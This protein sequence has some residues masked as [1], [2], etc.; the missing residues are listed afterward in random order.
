MSSDTSDIGQLGSFL[1]LAFVIPGF[2]YLGF[3][4]LYFPEQYENLKELYPGE[5]LPIF[6]G[7][8]GGLLLTSICFG[9]EIA[10]RKLDEVR[11]SILNRHFSMKKLKKI[12]ENRF[13]YMGQHKMPLIEAEEKGIVYLSQLTGQAYMHFNIFLGVFII[14]IFYILYGA[15]INYKNLNLVKISI[16]II[17]I[18]FNFFVSRTL[19]NWGTKAIDSVSV[20]EQENSGRN[21]YIFDL[22]DTLIQGNE[23]AMCEIFQQ[24]SNERTLNSH[25]DKQEIK[26]MMVLPLDIICKK[27]FPNVNETDI[28]QM[29]K[30]FRE[31]SPLIS[32]KHLKPI[33]GA[34]ET[35]SKL[36]KK[37]HLVAVVTTANEKIANQMIEWTGFSHFVTELKGSGI[38]S[39][40]EFKANCILELE[41]KYSIEKVYMIGDKEEDIK[42]GNK[43]SAIT[44]LYNP[45]L[46]RSK[47]ADFVI[48]SYNEFFTAIDNI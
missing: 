8:I 29:V 3:F 21:L 11:F 38:G 25:I 24:I 46:E 13:P 5:F 1:T 20:T 35:L 44:I 2:V 28:F 19:Y 42:A 27:L 16:G 43:A 48:A 32:P 33:E 7:V 36:K 45:K 26:E 30:R 34:I 4:I 41:K 15:S 18:G 40:I 47:D 17:I 10:G 14:L 12:F 22:H 9:I 31:L 39:P 37:G 6:L 23:D